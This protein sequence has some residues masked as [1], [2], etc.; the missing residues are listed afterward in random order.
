MKESKPKILIVG[1]FHMGSTPDL[2]QT[3]LDNILSPQ[4]QA[5]IAEVIVN[6]KRFEP[7]KIAVEVEKERQAEINKSYQDYLNNSFQVK[8]N[9]LH[10]IGFRLNAEMKNSEIFAVD[11]MRDVGQK[12]IGEV[13]E[14]AKANQP[15][16]FKRITETYLPNIAPDFNN[17]SISG[18]LKMCNDRT[19]LNLEQEM[20]MN[21]ARIGEG[22][23]Y[24]GIEWLRWWYQR[25]LIIFSNI[26]RLANTNDRILLLIGSAHVYLITQFLSESGLFEI[27]DLNKYI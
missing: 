8:V 3:G 4:R 23:N 27:E 10:Q 7:N 21:V 12:G 9:E 18:I 19:R 22:L 17:Q 24:M 2:I 6:L 13:M 14:W 1:T 5:E 20:Y 11:W 25:N 16:L 26:T 15:E